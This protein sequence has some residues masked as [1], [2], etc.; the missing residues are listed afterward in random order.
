MVDMAAKNSKP[1]RYVLG[2]S[3]ITPKRGADAKVESCPICGPVST[4]VFDPDTNET[5]CKRCGSVISVGRDAMRLDDSTA[6]INT[7]T[8]RRELG[9]Y[10]GGLTGPT[11]DLDGR[12]VHD[13]G[14]I[15][16]QHTW[17]NRTA[18]QDA[19]D[20]IRKCHV[21]IASLTD[22]LSLPSSVRLDAIDISVRACKMGLTSG[23]TAA[24]VAAASVLIASRKAGLPR[25]LHDVESA[26]DVTKLG[27]H[28]RMMCRALGE[29]PPPPDPSMYLPKTA[30]DLGVPASV[31]RMAA[32]MLDRLRAGGGTAGRNPTVLAAAAVYA[33]S[34]VVDPP[35]VTAEDVGRATGVST[36]SIRNCSRYLMKMFD[37]KHMRV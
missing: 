22:K 19:P 23:R 34:I 26:A 15:H 16:R 21:V 20:S 2:V 14:G 35:G 32:S 8:P 37:G 1:D 9:G 10:M 25:K 36:V 13:A 28:Y 17:H 31:S 7:P 3:N 4:C 5:I 11:K 24:A 29:Q 18:Y 6:D 27:M 33:A 12:M 30:S